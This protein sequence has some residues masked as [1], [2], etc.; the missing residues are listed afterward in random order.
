MT[1]QKIITE[2]YKLVP[3]EPT[4]EMKSAA[5]KHA[6]DIILKEVWPDGKYKQAVSLDSEMFGDAY[7]AMLAA[8]PE[9]SLPS[10]GGEAVVY[11]IGHHETALTEF[12]KSEPLASEFIK[13]H[14]RFNEQ[15][16]HLY[17]YPL[18]S[19]AQIDELKRSI[20]SLE[21]DKKKLLSDNKLLVDAYMLMRTALL[22]LADEAITVNQADQILG[23][24]K[25]PSV[26]SMTGTE[27]MI[28]G[29]SI[30]KK[31]LAEMEAK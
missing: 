20:T 26:S 25:P 16:F 27:R 8:A 31:A 30:M 28:Y 21:A 1:Q 18:D 12:F 6:G 9:N 23:L 24:P 4:E 11:G 2:Q 15:V 10:V 7:K 19:A 13:R 17:T 29:Q 3:V 5:V 14:D 22:W